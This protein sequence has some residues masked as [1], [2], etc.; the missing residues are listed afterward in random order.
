MQTFFF[1]AKRIFFKYSKE[2]TLKQ[3]HTS[4]YNKLQMPILYT[5]GGLWINRQKVK[6]QC[7]HTQSLS[8]EEF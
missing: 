5:I 3:I 4:T 6:Q 7:K 2:H 8:L 1:S